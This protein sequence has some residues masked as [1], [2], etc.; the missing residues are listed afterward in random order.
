[1]KRIYKSGMRGVS[2]I[3]LLIVVVVVAILGTIA[4]PAY[5]QYALRAQRTDA[6][7]ALLRIATAQEKF[8]MQNNTYTTNLA[9][10]PVGLGIPST[11]EGFY[12]LGVAAGAGGIGN[13]YTASATAPAGSGQ[14]A[15]LD[16]RTFQIDERST[17]AAANSGGVPNPNCW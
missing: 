8:F 9:A 12:N 5:R 10:A 6:K 16:C 7:S 3:E 4:F 15:D 13:S 11:D 1:M 14:F 2:L 17:R